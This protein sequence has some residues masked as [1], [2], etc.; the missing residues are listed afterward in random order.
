MVD[1][2]SVPYK[3]ELPHLRH[4]QDPEKTEEALF[5]WHL[6]MACAVQK[7]WEQDFV[8]PMYERRWKFT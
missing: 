2:R 3:A 5:L 8:E 6:M 4:L 1:L 7:C